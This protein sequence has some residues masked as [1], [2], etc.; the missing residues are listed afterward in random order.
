MS[1][2]PIEIKASR[3]LSPHL[4]IY[5]LQISS[6][7]SIGHRLSGIVLFFSIAII[8]WAFIFLVFN[9]FELP[10]LECLN[11]YLIKLVLIAASYCYFYHF[12]TGIRHLVWDTGCGFSINA[13]NMGGWV[14]ILCSILLTACYWLFM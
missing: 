10:C 11:N 4:G 8:C 1:R 12:C 7:L 9:N 2:D 5:K 14:A 13:I 6:V 3:P